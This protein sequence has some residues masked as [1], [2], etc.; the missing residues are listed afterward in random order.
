MT[1]L[2][3]LTIA[4]ATSIVLG[5]G[6]STQTEGKVMPKDFS[7]EGFQPATLPHPGAITFIE[8]WNDI[9]KRKSADE[10]PDSFKFLC[11]DENEKEVSRDKAKWCIPIVE[12]DIFSVDDNGK[13]VPFKEASSI[14]ITAYGPGHRF[15]RS[16]STA[17]RPPSPAP[18]SGSGNA[19]PPGDIGDASRTASVSDT[20]PQK[21]GPLTSPS[22]GTKLDKT[23]MPFRERLKRT[24]FDI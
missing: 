20:A 23:R 9:P 14:S 18:K 21:S 3:A 19:V 17:P 8:S 10:Y 11:L 6:C 13:S 2:V 16:L 5:A 22:F 7:L 4:L 15:V 12:F 24:I 1:K